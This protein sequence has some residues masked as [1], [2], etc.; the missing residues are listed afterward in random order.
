MFGGNRSVSGINLF[1]VDYDPTKTMDMGLAEMVGWGKNLQG[2]PGFPNDALNGLV[3][4]IN[5]LLEKIREVFKVDFDRI[6]DAVAVI[7]S[8]LD[9]LLGIFGGAAGGLGATVT[10]VIAAIAN[11]INNVFTPIL[12]TVQALLDGIF[13]LFGGTAGVGKTVAEVIAA[14]QGWLSGPFKL[15][16]DGIAGLVAKLQELL[17]GIF[18]LFGGVAGVGKTVAEVIAT[19]QGWLS[20]PFKLVQDGIAGALKTVQ[21]L[22]DGIFKVFGGTGINQTVTQ[23]IAQITSWLGG[24]FKAVQDG[25]TAITATVQSL[26]D[27]IFGLFGGTAGVNKTVA[28]AIA[29]ISGWMTNIFG[30]VSDGVGQIVNWLKTFF[31][32][33]VILFTGSAPKTL[34]TGVGVTE[35]LDA[36]SKWLTMIFGPVSDGLAA[37]VKA[38]NDFIKGVTGLFGGAGTTVSEALAAMTDW[39]KGFQ[40]LLDGLFGMFGGVAGTGKTVAEVLAAM[41]GWFSGIFKKLVDGINSL[42]SLIPG[43][44]GS[45]T[46]PIQGVIDVIG[47]ILGIG[48]SAQASAEKANMGILGIL[49]G[50]NGG[51]D[52]EFDY[53]LSANLPSPWVATYAGNATSTLGPDGKGYAKW[54]YSGFFNTWRAVH[55]RKTD[56]TMPNSNCVITVAL[57]EPPGYGSTDVSKF[58]IEALWAGT[59]T[60]QSRVRVEIGPTYAQ[61]QTVSA[62]GA[63]TNVGSKHTIPRVAARET[64]ALQIRNN[65]VSVMTVNGTSKIIQASENITVGNFP[66]RH[67]GFGS[68]YAGTL[69]GGPSSA[70]FMGI[71]WQD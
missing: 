33:I 29:A 42:A 10:E 39:F 66:G 35:A 46:N 53:K 50:Q 30:P 69:L 63:V 6:K 25:V 24:A 31:E 62:T 18:G 9:G 56:V 54:K 57:L 34:G 40:S 28:E 41:T 47:T 27:A 14:I 4:F 23:M 61:F 32:G 58:Y 70:S 15:V 43:F 36:I 21:D 48:Q 20:G 13:G 2:I 5:M 17:D 7:Q 59:S 22:I 8:L 44:S 1:K 19:I 12:K 49:A 67:F 3:D 65:T 45:I 51:G 71:T 52:D 11:W 37:I 38:F 55:Y 60:D 26:L 68:M 64:Y 16:Q